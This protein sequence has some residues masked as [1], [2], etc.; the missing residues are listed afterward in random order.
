VITL[1]SG[2][3]LASGNSKRMGQNKLLM[4][5]KEKYI[6]EYILDEVIKSDIDEIILVTKYDKIKEIANKCNNQTSTYEIIERKYYKKKNIKIVENLN[7]HKGQ[8]E[9]IKLGIENSNE[10]NDY[11]FFVS[12]QP[13]LKSEIINKIILE[14]KNDRNF[15]VTPRGNP[16][17]FPN[18]YKN[19][20]LS[21][22]G[23]VGGREIIKRVS[24][25]KYVD[26][27]EKYL[28]DIDNIE[29]YNKLIEG[30]TYE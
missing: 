13:L 30:K 8:S 14:F 18:K 10:I 27:C 2:I 5:Y 6:I 23:D 11:M 25:K 28:F 22:E 3:I 9:S 29:D 17:I 26:V 24:N 21:L 1:I 12:D 19:K 16:V 7:S 4:K 20:L 15:I